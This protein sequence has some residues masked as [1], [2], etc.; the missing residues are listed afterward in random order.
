VTIRLR[1]LV[2]LAATLLAAASL[3]GGAAGRPFEAPG[4]NGTPTITGVPQQGQTLTGHNGSWFCNPGPCTYAFQW[5]RCTGGCVDIAGAS[6]QDY[7]VTADD[8]GLKLRVAVTAT[9]YDCNALN[10]D[11]RFSSVTNWSSQTSTITA[12]PFAPP[13]ATAPPTVSGLLREGETLTASQGSWRGNPDRFAYS[14]Q[15]CNAAGGGC[16]P[17]GAAASSYVLDEADAGSTLRVVV[18]ATNDFG[19]GSSTS[20]TTGVVAAAP[21][22]APVAPS[23]VAPPTI[24]G[25]AY[26]G[27]TVSALPGTWSGTPTLAYTYQWQRCDGSGAVCSDLDGETSRD[28]SISDDDSRRTLKVVVTASNSAGSAT[29]ASPASALVGP[30]GIV[31]LESGSYSIPASSVTPPARLVVDKIVL[32]V[33]LRSRAAFALRVHVDDSRAYVVRDATVGVRGTK[34]G[35]VSSPAAA[36]TAD[37][38]WVAF[39][40]KPA[41]RLKL[42]RGRKLTLAIQART[43]AGA[44]VRYQVAIRLY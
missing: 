10:Q 38:G 17:T 23:S 24:V 6:E 8:V 43:P 35:T 4:P 15:R 42:G 20:A 32:P 2:A 44:A 1:T 13:S 41:K 26:E 40:L 37:D 14:W 28:Y 9:N 27:G 12:D 25:D 30:P 21:K 16:A 7:L 19:S 33:R 36:P 3:A 31:L 18:T 34:P 5:Q 11:C 22:V 29:A 39:T